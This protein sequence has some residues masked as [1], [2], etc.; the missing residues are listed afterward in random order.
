MHNNLD[1]QLQ[2]IQSTPPKG[3]QTDPSWISAFNTSLLTT[4]ASLSRDSSQDLS[5]LIKTPEFE[6]LLIAAQHLAAKENL[7]QEEATERLID[8]FRKIDHSWKQ[9]I[10]SRGLKS[11]T[12][13]L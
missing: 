4:R 11:L 13:S 7:S 5:A 3:D 12:E 10:I 2:T 6:C 9:I 8:V 1:L